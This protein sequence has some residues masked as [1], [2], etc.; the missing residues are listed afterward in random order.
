MFHHKRQI[1]FLCVVQIFYCQVIRY[2]IMIIISLLELWRP[3]CFMLELAS[4]DSV[5]WIK[6]L[7][8]QTS[9]MIQVAVLIKRW[10][11][12]GQFK[13]ITR[14]GGQTLQK[15]GMFLMTYMQRISVSRQQ[16]WAKLCEDA[17]NRNICNFLKIC[18]CIVIALMILQNICIS[19]DIFVG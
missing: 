16:G 6:I 15:A 7:F 9:C 11:F 4:T 18:F 12:G 13:Q 10:V 19:S 14:L 17:L 8:S 2:I 5:Y 3:V 1:R